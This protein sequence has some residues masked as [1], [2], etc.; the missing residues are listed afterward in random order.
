MGLPRVGTQRWLTY[1]PL[2]DFAKMLR[3]ECGSARKPVRMNP[4][5]LGDSDL[6][7]ASYESERP[8]S[9]SQT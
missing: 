3:D 6:D 1:L 4:M 9:L 5:G 7:F 2:K 8:E